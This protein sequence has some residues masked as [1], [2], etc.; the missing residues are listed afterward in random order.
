MTIGAKFAP[1]VWRDRGTPVQSVIA[2]LGASTTIACMKSFIESLTLGSG[3]VLVG[4]ASAGVTWLLCWLC[5][6]PLRW[7]W[8]VL[9]PLTLSCSLY[10]SPVWWF[11]ADAASFG[12][13]AL[14]VI[15]PWFLCGSFFSSLVA[16]VGFRKR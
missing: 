8:I 16:F 6:R 9:V 4:V 1:P 12:A 2:E 13:W 3:A 14:L 10:W 11:G 15:V 7:L 5:P